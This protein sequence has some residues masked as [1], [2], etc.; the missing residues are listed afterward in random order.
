MDIEQTPST[1]TEAHPPPG[2]EFTEK[3][4]L[5]PAIGFAPHLAVVS[6]LGAIVLFAF[7][8]TLHNTGFALDNKFIILEDPRLRDP[9]A[10]S[11]PRDKA[12]RD[13]CARKNWESV[14]A[15]FKEDYWWP[16]AVSG[17]YRP[18][19][20]LSYRLNYSLLNNRDNSTGYHWINFV[21]HWMAAVLVYFSVLVLMEKLWPAMFTAAIFATHPIVCESVSNLVGRADLFATVTVLAGFLCYAKSTTRQGW[22][23]V[24]WLALM[25]LVT[26]IGVF[27]KESAV[28]VLGVIGLYD[29]TYRLQR[30][31]ANWLVSV[32]KNFWGFFWQGYVALLPAFAALFAVR[33]WVFERLRPPE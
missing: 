7:A 32:A 9:C 24:P 1:T 31:H 22:G 10:G 12:E 2:E 4:S 5:W 28:V 6:V 15:I 8:N 17:L 23:K 16:K 27:C 18:L 14:K 26:L 19:T 20:T 33:A 21:S 29:F 25:S 11:V 3:E 13:E 30:K